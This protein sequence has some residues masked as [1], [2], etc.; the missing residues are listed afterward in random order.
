ME[1]LEQASRYC[2]LPHSGLQCAVHHLLSFTHDRVQMRLA[3]EALSVDFVDVLGAGRPSCKPS[4]FCYDLEAANRR[5]ISRSPSEFRG[6]WLA[7]EVRFLD[8]LG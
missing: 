3:L 2:S 5:L 7:C 8:R 6:D 4:V 1:E